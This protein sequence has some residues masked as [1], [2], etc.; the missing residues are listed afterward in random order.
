MNVYI[1]KA[2]VDDS[3]LLTQIQQE[4]FDDESRTFNH[5]PGG[6]DGYDSKESQIEFMKQGHYYK[7]VKNSEIVGG[8]IV[9]VGSNLV[10]NLGR[11]YIDPKHQN[12]GIGYQVIKLIEAEYPEAQKWW[13][14]TPSW[15]VGNHYFYEK[16]GYVK[17]KE[18]NGLFI[19]EKRMRS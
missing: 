11:I 16:S 9:F 6:P 12:Q 19:Y 15:S 13:L 18:E 2:N 3:E 8:V 4:S 1:E 7:I 5:E 10:Y 17:T 14:D